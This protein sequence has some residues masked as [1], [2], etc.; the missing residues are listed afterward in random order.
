MREAGL[1]VADTLQALRAA[2]QPGVATAD[3]DALAE[4]RIRAAGAVPSFKGYQ[5]YP[6]TIC[7]SVDE[8]IV[9]GIPS[10]TKR[11]R[12]GS[13]ISIDCGAIM[14]GWHADAAVTAGVGEISAEL[15]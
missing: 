13:V 2:A 5:G 1:V 8:E 9:H 7:T 6:A 10:R 11:L 15:A 14:D 12:E 3:L 4:E